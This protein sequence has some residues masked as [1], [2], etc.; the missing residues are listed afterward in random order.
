MRGLGIKYF[1]FLMGF[2]ALFFSLILAF[3]VGWGHFW[4]ILSFFAVF[5]AV[6]YI[7]VYFFKKNLEQK[8]KEK[9]KNKIFID[10]L[11]KLYNKNYLTLS[12]SQIANRLK[13]NNKK[14]VVALIDLDQFKEINDS[15][16]HEYGDL[17]LKEIAGR[18]KQIVRKSD[19]VSRF[20]G[21]E[22]VIVLDEVQKPENIISLIE[23]LL[24][25]INEK[26]VLNGK[27]ITT[28]SSI[29]LSVFP[30]DSED[31][32]KLI[33]YADT[34]M[35]EAKKVKGNSFEFYKKNMGEKAKEK[36]ELKNAIIEAIEKDQFTVFFQPQIN[37]SGE[38]YGFE[39]LVRW[40]HPQKG[41]I[42]PFKFIPLAT[43]LGLIDKI[44]EIV[45]QKTIKQYKEWEEKG[46]KL[47]T[48]SCNFTM[49]DIERGNLIPKIKKIIKRENFNPKNLVLE[50]TEDNIM[51]DPNKTINYIKELSS[52]GIHIAV[53]DFGT[54][55][56]SLSYLNKFPLNELK[57]DR[58][59]IMDL[60]HNHDNI[61]IV[62]S[63]ITLAN[64][65]DLRIVAE[66]VET[67]E[68]KDF[69]LSLGVDL[70]QGYLYSPPIP[71][72]EFENKFLK[73]KH[74]S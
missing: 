16:G 59:F 63:V 13:R 36:L 51:S 19:I 34:A 45:I 23:R 29:G 65:F 54:G 20:S 18:I 69:I 43:E 44:D 55:Y 37:F 66:G 47:G 14:A 22:F 52:E 21:D 46:Y 26:F 60:P 7:Y 40:I 49:F 67:H 48:V 53:D 27:E 74:A 50:I 39:A 35:F 58:N 73:D 61:K 32:Q 1:V 33:T 56:S 38:L 17:Y 11:T 6:F 2:L 15:L 3:L 28:T 24:L 71:A 5:L 10:P 70:V 42:S 72:N 4:V 68:Q 30:D 64:N 41:L 62:K 12:F 31:I 57:I 25:K 9:F 8:Y